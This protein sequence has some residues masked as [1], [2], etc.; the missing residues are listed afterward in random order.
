MVLAVMHE[1]D[2]TAVK[3]WL[4]EHWATLTLLLDV[5]AGMQEPMGP[6][7]AHLVS[8]A[9][10]AG[11]LW[12]SA[13]AES[14]ESLADV[15]MAMV[16]VVSGLAQGDFDPFGTAGGFFV[17]AVG[18]LEEA[19]LSL[20]AG[21]GL[22]VDALRSCANKI[23]SMTS[24]LMPA[25]A[26]LSETAASDLQ[27]HKN[28]NK[29]N[30]IDRSEAESESWGPWDPPYPDMESDY[31]EEVAAHIDHL[32]QGLV[33]L[34]SGGSQPDLIN[35]LFRSSHS[36]KGQSGQMSVRPIEKV[37]HKLEDVLALVRESKLVLSASSVEV[38]LSVIDS[39]ASMLEQLRQTRCIVHPIGKET[40]RMDG[41]IQGTW[42]SKSQSDDRSVGRSSPVI[43]PTTLSSNASSPEVSPMVLEA[44]GPAPSVG[45]DTSATSHPVTD[46]A[47]KET[48]ASSSSLSKAQYLRVDF[49]KVDRALNRVGDLFINKI[50]L[51]DTAELY[52]E[53]MF[54]VRTLQNVLGR[55]HGSSEE[56]V[57]LTREDAVHLQEGLAALEL[58]MEQAADQLGSAMGETDMISSDLRDQVMEM[59]M[60]PVNTVLGRLSRVVFDALQ[61][62]NRAAGASPKRARLE[63]IGADAEIDK[64]MANM[65]E[66]PLVH[67]VRNAVAH[68]IESVAEREAAGKVAEGTIRIRAQQ[69]GSRFVIETTDDGRGMDPAVLGKV[70][71]AKGIATKEALEGM[72]EREVLGLIF[73]PGFTTAER[74]DDL[75]GR[76]VGLDEVMDKI[77]AIKGS[78]DVSSVMGKGSRIELS[79]PL[80]LA[81]T[82]VVLGELDTDTLAIP[83]S[84]VERV[85]HLSESDIEAMGDA[86]IFTLL[87]E[88]VPL[89]R[90]D[91]MLGMGRPASKRPD[92]CYVTVVR[93]GDKRMG[94]ALDR[95]RGQRE[96]VVKG[97]GTLLKQVPFVAGSTLLG[98]RCVL[99][100]DPAEIIDSVGKP[101]VRVVAPSASVP[102]S[103]KRCALLVDD[104][105]MTRLA[106]RRVFEQAGLEVYEAGDGMEGLM[107]AQQ[108]QYHLVSTDVVMPRMDGYEL[109]R[110]LRALPAFHRTPILMVTSKDLEVDRRAGFEAGVDRYVTKP[111]ERSELLQLV[112]EM[113]H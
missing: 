54:H 53:L 31:V 110:R 4:D 78:V 43:V 79:L 98:D 12:L 80:T 63:V 65:L 39:L 105:A 28:I 76:G 38:L 2:S 36:I 26:E 87:G 84:A 9:V 66:V 59:R 29:I 83:M 56:G 8:L 108:R 40:E 1:A 7:P 50:R 24:C 101:G 49:E 51:N 95:M 102:S 99:I 97:L 113:I 81:I 37:A 42:E 19:F 61:K 14:L 55:A 71:L 47:P 22:N 11:R 20:E 91:E 23:T 94:L 15:A 58:E 96:V 68:G 77:R 52:A 46:S 72:T 25:S 92:S 107:M 67:I 88:T 18:V 90:L 5:S 60:V 57:W 16:P 6:D 89:V 62:E 35:D 27:N 112:E 45:F 64:M 85:V 13:L 109:T 103:S 10:E 82:T 73:R 93:L 74:A 21:D 48:R 106:L 69:Q 100:V 111:F 104:D 17:Q 33:Q 75:K 34:A 3:R 86:E 70:A 41:V 32:Q 30:N 44:K